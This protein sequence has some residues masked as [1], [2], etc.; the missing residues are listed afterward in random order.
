MSR[1][2]VREHDMQEIALCSKSFESTKDPVK[3][4]VCEVSPQ[5]CS[6]III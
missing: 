3:E 6:S 4:I 1:S 5:I 2:R